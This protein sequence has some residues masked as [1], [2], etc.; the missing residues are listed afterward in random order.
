MLLSLDS[1]MVLREHVTMHMHP[2]PRTDRWTTSALA[3]AVQSSIKG[4]L[5]MILMTSPMVMAM[6]R[7]EEPAP[8]RQSS[9]VVD[10]SSESVLEVLFPSLQSSR[11]CTL[12]HH[13]MLVLGEELA[14][15]RVAN[16][17]V[18][19]RSEELSV[20]L[21]IVQEIAVAQERRHAR[22]TQES[23]NVQ[24]PLGDMNVSTSH[25]PRTAMVLVVNATEMMASASV[26]WVTPEQHANKPRGAL[27][28]KSST[29][30]A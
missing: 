30:T 21:K 6:T 20:N 26:R 22:P 11:C 5:T 23:A 2:H 3:V 19:G 16:V 28:K 1:T 14:L 7:S 29:K 4:I 15:M 17:H 24:S 12:A 9:G 27:Q 25:A 13:R 18:H 10:A 8:V